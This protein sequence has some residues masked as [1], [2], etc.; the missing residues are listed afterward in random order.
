MPSKQGNKWRGCVMIEGK[1]YQQLFETK[2]EAK[3]FEVETK[4]QVKAELTKEPTPG[5]MELRI[6]FSK[7]LDFAEPRFTKGVFEDKRILL[8]RL[9]ERWGGGIPVKNITVDMVALYLEA[10][11]KAVSGNAANRDRKNLLALWN[12]GM[13]RHDLQVN[14]VSKVDRF[15]HDRS[16][17]HTPTEED[18]L[19][20]LAAS[21]REEKVMLTAYLNTAARRSEIFRWT[22]NDD[23]NFEKREVRLGTRKTSDGSM[24]Y[25]WLPMNDDLY[26]ELW[27]LWNNRKFKESPF[28]FVDSHPG[29]NY[30]KP[31]IIRRKFMANLCERAQVQPFGFHALRRHV[32]SVLADTHKVSSKTIQRILRHRNVTTTERYIQNVNRDLSATMDLLNRGEERG[33]FPKISPTTKKE[34]S[35]LS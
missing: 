30:G 25:E 13:K 31:F 26:K 18:V 28:V 29:P 4:K 10:R 12:W 21:T 3:T 6:F 35:L 7:Y 15:R 27:W 9:S 20:V 2:E 17:L 19:K 33:N 34:P 5:D 1:K 22:W 8:V 24:S 14:P 23:I 16:V 11:A 32:A